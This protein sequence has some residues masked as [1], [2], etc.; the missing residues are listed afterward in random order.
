MHR[1]YAQR[2]VRLTALGL[3]AASILFALLQST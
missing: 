1:V 2:V 3:T